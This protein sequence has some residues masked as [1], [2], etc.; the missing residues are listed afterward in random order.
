KA[1]AAFG[2]FRRELG[3]AAVRADPAVGGWARGFRSLQAVLSEIEKGR[4]RSVPVRGSGG[5]VRGSAQEGQV[6]PVIVAMVK[7]SEPLQPAFAETSGSARVAFEDG[8]KQQLLELAQR[9]SRSTDEEKAL[10]RLADLVGG[11]E[12]S[13]ADWVKVGRLT[14]RAF[15]DVTVGLLRL[16]HE[17]WQEHKNVLEL[18]SLPNAVQKV[19]AGV[20]ASDVVRRGR[21]W[22]AENGAAVL[23]GVDIGN[24]EGR[25]FAERWMRLAAV[26]PM[27]YERRHGPGDVL[28]TA[29]SERGDIAL[30]QMLF[31]EARVAYAHTHRASWAR[32]EL[33]TVEQVFGKDLWTDWLKE[34]VQPTSLTVQDSRGS[35]LEKSA[36]AAESS[37]RS[38]GKRARRRTAQFPADALPPMLLPGPYDVRVL[39]RDGCLSLVA[40]PVSPAEGVGI[41]ELHKIGNRRQFP[42]IV[43]WVQVAMAGRLI[44]VSSPGKW[45]LPI[46]LDQHA[47]PEEKFS[48]ILNVHGEL[49]AL[50]RAA[51]FWDAAESPDL[52][53]GV[54]Y[55]AT[56]TSHS[57]SM[58][59]VQLTALHLG[60]SYQVGLN[61]GSKVLLTVTMPTSDGGTADDKFTVWTVDPAT[62][63]PTER[64]ALTWD[65]SGWAHQ[66][67]TDVSVAKG[68]VLGR[69]GQA[70]G[71]LFTEAYRQLVVPLDAREAVRGWL[72]WYANRGE[73]IE[74][75]K[76]VLSGTA[77]QS[78]ADRLLEA[79]DE[80]QARV[81]EA[82]QKS[83]SWQAAD[84]IELAHRAVQKAAA[85]WSDLSG[86]QTLI[87]ADPA[88][89]LSGNVD[90]SGRGGDF[91]EWRQAWDSERL[92]GG[93]PSDREAKHGALTG[94][95]RPAHA[96][97][98]D[99]RDPDVHP[100]DVRTTM[101]EGEIE[102]EIE[103]GSGNKQ[104]VRLKIFGP[105]RRRVWVRV[106]HVRHPVGRVPVIAVSTVRGAKGSSWTAWYPL[107]DGWRISAAETTAHGLSSQEYRIARSAHMF[108]GKSG[109]LVP[110]G[111]VAFTYV[112]SVVS[113]TSNGRTYRYH[114]LS[115][116]LPAEKIQASIDNT[117]L[118]EN[119]PVL[120]VAEPAWK[121]GERGARLT[122]YR[123][124]GPQSGQA[125]N[126]V[127]FL[128]KPKDD[129]AG[130]LW[131]AWD[132]LVATVAAAKFVIDD[133]DEQLFSDE[134]M[135]T[136][137]SQNQFSAEP[138][139]KD[140]ARRVDTA[141]GSGWR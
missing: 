10:R 87:W 4:G 65:Q 131:V 90:P 26:L 40:M 95:A 58:G 85:E 8:E 141:G 105:S 92:L 137:V 52:N 45:T 2:D 14:I 19:R 20:M 75:F 116:G 53:T 84:S 70:D 41:K 138:A 37:T 63:K 134:V 135:R 56:V 33:E 78:S 18:G 69:W 47:V 28:S 82:V 54:A 130:R 112:V 51:D 98:L 48:K 119:D 93:G 27:L 46:W 129:R 140:S 17:Y 122:V 117:G 100:I 83:P 21:D 123:Q 107:E 55:A 50:A 60:V 79:V 91:D 16:V 109:S 111:A 71:D 3:M 11:T 132:D 102:I 108:L 126:K 136:L 62:G 35:R 43:V 30:V 64:Q 29:A 113:R 80:V 61:L 31:N 68:R 89:V 13:Q 115:L 44:L 76:A 120:V 77:E 59:R 67:A 73:E 101:M 9:G 114:Y 42:G 97:G 57:A 7:A 34:D 15:P 1:K 25:R 24:A 6:E 99:L 96:G 139:E 49:E 127:G 5:T 22:F 128:R 66:F 110:S 38:A 81:N 23:A 118:E 86:S 103:D 74:R 72:T 12:L 94:P 133:T 121:N 32:P 124:G 125:L 106:Q 36:E 104:S 88:M 39:N